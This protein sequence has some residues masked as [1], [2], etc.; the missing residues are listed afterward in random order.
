MGHKDTGWRPDPARTYKGYDVAE[1]EVSPHQINDGETDG[2]IEF[3]RDEDGNLV[4]DE[5]E[6]DDE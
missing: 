6:R 2:E 4:L 3:E 5:A 1:Y